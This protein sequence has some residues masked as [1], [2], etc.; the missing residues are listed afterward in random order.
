[1][2]ATPT[3]TFSE[4]NKW[5][6]DIP[7]GNSTTTSISTSWMYPEGCRVNGNVASGISSGQPCAIANNGDAGTRTIIFSAEL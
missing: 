5:I 4:Q 6:I 7:T 1:M 2:R 3:A